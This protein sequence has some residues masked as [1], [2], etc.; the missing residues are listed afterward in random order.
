MITTTRLSKREQQFV[1]D[2]TRCRGMDWARIGMMVEVDGELGTIR[3]M[4]S[5]ANIDVEFVNQL[6][7]G[8]GTHNCHPW[9]ETRYFDADGK[10]IKDYTESQR[11]EGTQ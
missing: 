4:N 9:W 3:G 1:D 2:M 10:I 11:K 6:K 8:K 7:M 5:S